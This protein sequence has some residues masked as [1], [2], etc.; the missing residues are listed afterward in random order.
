MVRMMVLVLG[1][2]VMV[3]AAKKRQSIL[4]VQQGRKESCLTKPCLK[5]L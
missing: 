4:P 2:V 5:G 3:T 1:V